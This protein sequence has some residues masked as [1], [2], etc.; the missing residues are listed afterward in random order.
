MD[1]N[2]I[3]KKFRFFFDIRG[4]ETDQLPNAPTSWREMLI[5]Y[6]RSKTYSG[7]LRNI[8]GQLDFAGKG[9]FLLRREYA[10]YRL[11]ARMILRVE[12]D[13]RQPYNTYQNIY[14]G[15]VDFS[16]KV[17]S[18]TSFTIG[19]K[20]NDFSVNID[21]YDSQ[22]FAIPL[23]G[24]INLELPGIQLTENPQLIFSTSPDFRSNAFFQMAIAS[25]NQLSIS[26]SVEATGFLQ[27]DAP[28][29]NQQNPYF[30]FIARTNGKVFL[31]GNIGAS[32]NSGRF[33]FNIYK[34]DGR[35]VKTLYETPNLSVTTQQNFS[36][37]F[38]IDIIKGDRLFFYIKRTGGVLNSF[39]GVN[40]QNGVLYLSYQTITPPT[41]CQALSGAQLFGA[42]LQAMNINQD[43][44]P[45]LPVPF[46]S[47]LLS[48]VLDA[49][50]FTCSDSIRSAQGSIFIAGDTIGPGIYK[51]IQGSVTYAANIYGINQQFGFVATSTT[52]TGSG[53]IQKIQSIFVGNVYNIGD[54]LQAGGTYLVEGNID[55]TATYHAIVY[56]VGQFFKYFLGQETFTAS[57]DSVFVKQVAVDSQIVISFADF[58]QCLKSVMGGDC[59]F[60]IDHAVNKP[61]I[62]TLAYVY[63]A[64]INQVS[65][66]NVPKDW[67]SECAI[68]IMYNTIKV[69]QNDQQYDAVNGAQEVS[70]E[71][72]YTSALLTPVAELN[73]I[74]PVRF[75]PYGIETVRIT[76]N[77]TAASR[78]DNNTFGIWINT[79]PVATTPF[80]YYRP[81][82]SEGLLLPIIGVDPSYYNWMLSPKRNLLRGSRYLAS[83]FFGMTGYQLRLTGYKKNVAMITVGLD[84]IR[85]SE[86]EPVEI[87]G[88][89]KPYFIAEYFTLIMPG[90]LVD[91]IEYADM[92]FDVNGVNLK[93]FISNYKVN[94][95][96][97]KP[98]AI[99]LLLTADNDLSKL[100]R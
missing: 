84:G 9:A 53:V 100:N 31:T 37:N 65:L 63:R 24:A 26:P 36:W 46:Q 81:L 85:V 52:F 25:Y 44:G 21:A 66:G 4:I 95:G 58:F 3:I 67:Q 51:V 59:A 76:Q 42:L 48:G 56:Q 14:T 15:Q 55:S 91:G 74:S 19:A 73:L 98:Q 11:L 18:Q 8:T 13:T 83:I 82:G 71:Q 64:G 57:D 6:S 34:S 28:L 97:D 1:L 39:Q 94:F 29:F 70:S 92:N 32:C 20:S 78:S 69:G 23:T 12:M 17:D 89:G 96:Q 27:T 2:D 40:M 62:E 33:Q 5:E 99:K 50:Y 49:L 35:L 80:T 61:F 60:G 68:D 16:K 41:M 30:F 93:A 38:A 72:Y 43:S 7:L 10:K 77:D 87:G 47:F 22:Q 88:L 86:S 45:N 75:D 79:T 90:Q 54:S